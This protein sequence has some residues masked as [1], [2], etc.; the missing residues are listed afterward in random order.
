MHRSPSQTSPRY[1]SGMLDA[2][3][4]TAALD[5]LWRAHSYAVDVDRDAWDFAVEIDEFRRANVSNSELR[6]L[7]SQ[8]LAIQADE[9]GAERGQRR[10]RR[11]KSTS[12][13]VNSCFVISEAGL[14]LLRRMGRIPETRPAAPICPFAPRQSRRSNGGAGSSSCRVEVPDWNSDR[15]EL[16]LGG[17]LV[18]RYRRPA[19]SQQVILDGFQLSSWPPLL[20]D[21]LPLREACCPKRRLHD[22]IKRL[23][24]HH[25]C[26]AIRFSGDGSG[27]GVIWEFIP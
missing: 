14:A 19:A 11:S 27:R 4:P 1:Q 17:R 8:E 21:P 23:N 15:R 16:C 3:L 9:I 2:L 22:A 26:V 18:K 25:L 13:D 7:V 10:F 12:L 6:W 24:R 20:V 5:I